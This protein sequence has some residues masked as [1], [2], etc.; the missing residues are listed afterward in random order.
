MSDARL[1]VAVVAALPVLVIGAS[2]IRLDVERLRRLA[3]ASAAATLLVALVVTVSPSV[4][5]FSIRTSALTRDPGGEG[6]GR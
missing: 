2:Y 5:A 1:W 4:R 6:W 3:V